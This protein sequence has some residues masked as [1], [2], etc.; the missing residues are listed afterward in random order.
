MRFARQEKTS[1]R[2]F[3]H[4]RVIE[5]SV[6]LVDHQISIAGI[7]IVRKIVGDLPL[8]MAN[9]NQ[10]QQVMM[11]LMMNASH[12]MEKG[13]TLTVSLEDDKTAALIK[14]ADTGTG[15]TDE[16]KKTSVLSHSLQ[17]N[18]WERVQALDF[19]FSENYSRSQRYYWCRELCW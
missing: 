8:C 4:A 15:M 17:Q 14:I 11:N 10:L 3:F 18:L 13:G 1:H 6:D 16:V 7:K 2:A 9:G 5:D 12:A 19:L